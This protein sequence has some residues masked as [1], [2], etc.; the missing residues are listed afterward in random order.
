ME[1]NDN[2]DLMKVN[3]LFLFSSKYH[4]VVYYVAEKPFYDSIKLL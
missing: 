2:V 1:I 4:Y 3:G